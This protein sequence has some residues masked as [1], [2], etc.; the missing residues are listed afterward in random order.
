MEATNIVI[1]EVHISTLKVGD[2]VKHNG[3]VQ[4]LGKNNICYSSFMGTSIFGNSYNLGHIKV[5]K[6]L[7]RVETNL[8]VVFR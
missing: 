5:E 4:T 3:L 7:F 1:K 6:V 8:G 2:T